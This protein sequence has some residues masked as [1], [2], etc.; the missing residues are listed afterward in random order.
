MGPAM[1][2][3]NSLIRMPYG[4]GEQNMVN[5]VP[6]IVALK[7]LKAVGQLQP[8]LQKSAIRNMES[9]YQRELN[10]KRSDGSYSAFGES[11]DAGS[12]W[13]TAF[14][15]KSFAQ[16]KDYIFVDDEVIKQG[17]QFLKEQQQSTGE[18]LENGEVH[19]SHL[20]GGSKAGIPL[21]AF[22]LIALLQNRVRLSPPPNQ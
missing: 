20:Q 15:V 14:V 21:T 9:G 11:D 6:N 1:S 8:A 3:I 2:N 12:T 7:Y 13:L 10:Y 22:V 4:C 16:A 17:M 5:F 19:S 18:F